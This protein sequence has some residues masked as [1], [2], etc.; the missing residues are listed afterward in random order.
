VLTYN[1]AS[2]YVANVSSSDVRPISFIGFEA[3]DAVDTL[4]GKHFDGE[5]WAEFYPTLERQK[6]T[7]LEVRQ[8]PNSAYLRPDDCRQYN[9]INRPSPG[10]SV[11]FWTPH[12]GAT[13][14]RVLWQGEEIARCPLVEP[15]SVRICEIYLP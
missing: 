15:G 6:C 2:F 1:E 7:T 5:G 8:F 3:L 12:A 14:F 11:E 13:Q 4:T 10:S 9:A